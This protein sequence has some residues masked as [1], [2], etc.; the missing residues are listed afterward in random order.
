VSRPTN[1]S[2][3]SHPTKMKV[4]EAI[5]FATALFGLC[6]IGAGVWFGPYGYRFMAAGV[7]LVILGV[8]LIVRPSA[9]RLPRIERAVKLVLRWRAG[10]GP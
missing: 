3:F 7:G 9:R 6:A 2:G 5:G 8:E 1:P 4:V 10:L